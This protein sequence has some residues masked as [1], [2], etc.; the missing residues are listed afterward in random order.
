MDDAAVHFR[1][2]IPS[3]LRVQIQLVFMNKI[4]NTLKPQWVSPFLAYR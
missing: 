3:D 4:A 2:P 1:L